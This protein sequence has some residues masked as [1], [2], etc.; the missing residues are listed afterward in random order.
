MMRRHRRPRAVI[1]ALCAVLL[2]GAFRYTGFHDAQSRAT[3]A[4]ATTWLDAQQQPDGSFETAG[5]PGFETPDAVL[6]IAEN[7]QSTAKWNKASALAA[8]EAVTA[9]GNSALHALDD[10]TDS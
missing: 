5:F 8:V 2:L 10:L 7:A 4:K 6:A 3:A 9:H 1:G